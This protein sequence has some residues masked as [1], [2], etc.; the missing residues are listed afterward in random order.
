MNTHLDERQLS[1]AVAGL[2]LDPGAEKHLAS[3]LSCRQDVA[4]FAALIDAR[5]DEMAAETPDW[6]RQRSEILLRLPNVPGR[7]PP[8]ARRWIRPLLAAAAAVVVAVGLELLWSPAPTVDPIADLE[9]P[10][11]QILADVD[12]VLADESLPG[13]ESI[14]PGVDD[15]ESYFENGAS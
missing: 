6:D 10:I 9:V 12:A 2:D 4:A 3:C 11:E 14:D 8:V 1:A 7:R 13:F 15:L 5:R